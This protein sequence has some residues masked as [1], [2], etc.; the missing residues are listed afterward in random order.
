MSSS[1]CCGC[2]DAFG[3]HG[4]IYQCDIV[5]DGAVEQHA[6]LKNDANLPAQPGRIDLGYIDSIDQHAPAFGQVK[7]LNKLGDCAFARSGGADNSDYLA[8]PHFEIDVV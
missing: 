4:R 1:Q 8:G 6:V 2:D 3:R 7:A 5:P